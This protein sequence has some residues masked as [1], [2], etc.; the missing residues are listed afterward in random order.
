M[1]TEMGVAGTTDASTFD[2]RWAAWVA[3][4]AAHDKKVKKRAVAAVAVIATGL[5][6]WAA[7]VV[8]FG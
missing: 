5:A 1:Q 7:I 6:L 4:G 2:E 3:K 8:L